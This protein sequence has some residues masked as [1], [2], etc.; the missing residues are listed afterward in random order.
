MSRSE[1]LWRDQYYWTLRYVIL[2]W[3]SLICMLPFDLAQFDEEDQKGQTAS[4]IE[5]IA[6]SNL[7]RAG[8]EREAAG[9][10][11]AR[12]YT[13]YVGSRHHGNHPHWNR[14]DMASKF[15][16]FLEWC[17][18]TVRQPKGPFTVSSSVSFGNGL[19]VRDIG[20]DYWLSSDTLRGD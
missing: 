2:L 6:K 11:L 5:E 17:L 9:I 12:L 15:P 18:S 7:S 8:V 4:K 14:K 1:I 3:L 16:S 19:I 13:R 10:L 20:I